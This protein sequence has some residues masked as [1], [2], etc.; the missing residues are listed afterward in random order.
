MI[1]A[2]ERLRDELLDLRLDYSV[3]QPLEMMFD[4]WLRALYAIHDSLTRNDE[5]MRSESDYGAELGTEELD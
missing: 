4:M 3:L 1:E 5:E 2:Y